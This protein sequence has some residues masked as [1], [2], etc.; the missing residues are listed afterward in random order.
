MYYRL[1]AWIHHIL[2]T[3][4]FRGCIRD[5]FFVN[6]PHNY[7]SI[8]RLQIHKPYLPVVNL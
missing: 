2:F 1:V 4:G 8:S 3:I 5:P 6:L 7:S